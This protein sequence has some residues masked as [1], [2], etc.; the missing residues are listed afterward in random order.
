MLPVTY[1]YRCTY[2][3]YLYCYV[4]SIVITIHYT[5]LLLLGGSSS[6]ILNMDDIGFEK[7]LYYE[8]YI[9]IVVG[10]S[11]SGLTTSDDNS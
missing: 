11:S 3:A 10:Q 5:F 8:N 4:A 6:V 9:Y 1:K 2:V 7:L